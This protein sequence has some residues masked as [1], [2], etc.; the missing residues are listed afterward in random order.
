MSS[1]V[2]FQV[3]AFHRKY[4]SIIEVVE[5]S[6]YMTPLIQMNPLVQMT[7]LILVTSP[8]LVVVTWTSKYLLILMTS[9]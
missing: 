6:S 8:I 4:A 1:F 5:M 9:F 3:S 2:I 7:T